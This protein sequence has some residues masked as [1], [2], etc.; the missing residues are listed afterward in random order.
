MT[1]NERLVRF[2]QAGAST[3]VILGLWQVASLFF[4]DY[5]F[6]PVPQIAKRTLDIFV[7]GPLLMEVLE[8]AARIFAGLLGAFLL[9]SLM[10]LLIGRSP[11]T[12]SYVTP[13]LVF[14]QGIPALSWVVIAI[15]WFH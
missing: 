6:P 1:S 13:V 15:I 2:A 3:L 5:L 11:R 9:G 4:P 8:T 7:S 14:L 12:G 10:T